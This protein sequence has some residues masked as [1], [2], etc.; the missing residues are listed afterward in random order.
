MERDASVCPALCRL[1]LQCTVVLGRGGV[2]ARACRVAHAFVCSCSQHLK[3]V[4]GLH[5]CIID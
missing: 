1:S 2:V 5:T 4:N 3:E